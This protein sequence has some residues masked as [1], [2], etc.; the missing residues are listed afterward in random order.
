M[1]SNGDQGSNG[2][3][4]VDVQAMMAAAET[5]MKR[6][7]MKQ[8]EPKQAG[9]MDAWGSTWPVLVAVLCAEAHKPGQGDPPTLTFWCDRDGMRGVLHCRQEAAKLFGHGEGIEELLSCLDSLLADPAAPWRH[10][11]GTRPA[12]SPRRR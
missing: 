10:E 3:H 1:T 8:E 5:A 2:S 12:R 4:R 9:N 7:R 6:L 11:N